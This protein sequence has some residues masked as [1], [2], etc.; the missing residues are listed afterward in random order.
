MSHYQAKFNSF[1]FKGKTY[2]LKTIVKCKDDVYIS[3]GKIGYAHLY[4][5]VLIVNHYIDNQ[6]I[7]RYSYTVFTYG[8]GCDGFITKKSPDEIIDY[9]VE[10]HKENNENELKNEYYKDSEVEYMYL[11]WVIY[12]IAMFFS[13]IFIDFLVA[14]ACISLVFFMWRAKK[15]KKPKRMM[16]GYDVSKRVRDLNNEWKIRKRT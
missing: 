10:V 5:L 7:R 13:I 6:G 8:G 14:W 11:A 16:Y 12:I 4:P 3:S 9:I 15:L 2:P 1:E